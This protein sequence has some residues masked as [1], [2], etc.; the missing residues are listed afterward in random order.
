[1]DTKELVNSPIFFERNRVFRS[2]LGGKLFKDFFGGAI[3]KDEDGNVPEEWV[4]STVMAL[5]KNPIP[6][7]G[8]SIVAGT[9]TTFRDLVEAHKAEI[10]GPGRNEFGVLVKGLDSAIRLPIQ[11]HPD[12]PFSREHFKSEYGKTE[13]WL[14]L[15]TRENPKIYFGFKDKMTEEKFLQL[16]EESETNKEAFTP[17]LTAVTPKVGD[18]Y[19]IHAKMVHAIG[20]GCLLLEVQEPT[21]FTIQVEA[22][23]G[24]YKVS[25]Y[26]K[27]L[28]LTQDVAIKCFDF[29]TYGQKA[30]DMSIVKP[31]N[32]YDKDG[33]V[34]DC[35]ISYEDTPCFGT[36]RYRFS[37]GKAVLEGAPAIYLVTDGSGSL[38]WNGKTKD[39]KKGDYFVIPYCLKGKVEATG[40]S[41]E[42]AE[43]LPPKI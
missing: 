43:C 13:M 11:A 25:E 17:Y 14:I 33:V 27:Y 34:K 6:R 42:I 3:D 12:K 23:C 20:A 2:Y 16:A 21:D 15:A 10:L 24:D 22:W 8:L 5:N 41:L 37:G 28:G 19:L 38:L 32:I 36:N 40:A 9:D 7:E 26:E 39:I 1:M 35:L 29:E 30:I 31:R 4:A 18:V